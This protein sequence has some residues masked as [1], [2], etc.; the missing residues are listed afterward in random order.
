MS[1]ES[2][3][4]KQITNHFDSHRTVSAMQFGFRAGHGC[5]SATH[6][7]LNDII[8]AIDKRHYYVA[9]FLVTTFL[10]ADST[11]LVSQMIAS[12]GL[13][14]TSLIE[15]SVSNRSACCPDLLQSLWGCHRVKF[16]GQL[17]TLNISMMSL[18][19]QVILWATSIQT[20]PF[21]IPLAIRWTLCVLHILVCTSITPV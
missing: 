6:K 15:F 8:T 18:L 1:F 14:T 12:P 7:V 20:T 13:P 4:N 9:V 10:L 11:D 19:L 2:Q 5:T 17:F 3:V 16:S 21:C